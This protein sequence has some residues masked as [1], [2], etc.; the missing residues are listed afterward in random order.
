MQV[1]FYW[2]AKYIDDDHTFEEKRWM[3]NVSFI[4]K[5]RSS[6]ILHVILMNQIKLI[7][8]K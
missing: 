2:C 6:D 8:F 3:K 5:H 1:M 4:V 7:Q